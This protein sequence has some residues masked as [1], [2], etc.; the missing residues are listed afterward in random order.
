MRL[1]HLLLF[2][3]I[4]ELFADTETFEIPWVHKSSFNLMKVLCACFALSNTLSSIKNILKLSSNHRVQT[5]LN[6]SNIC[7]QQCKN[8]HR[9]SQTHEVEIIVM[10]LKL[11]SVYMK[12]LRKRSTI[13]HIMHLQSRI[14]FRF[15]FFMSLNQSFDYR[16]GFSDEIH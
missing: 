3:S 15:L 12:K 8:Y 14:K 5:F 9:K 10:K 4:L 16:I 11:P 13:L 1:F 7:K 6:Q 2:K